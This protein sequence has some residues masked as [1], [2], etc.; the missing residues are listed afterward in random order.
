MDGWERPC[1]KEARGPARE[2]PGKEGS[3]QQEQQVQRPWGGM[4]LTSCRNGGEEA[5]AAGSKE[6][7][8]RRGNQLVPGASHVM[9]STVPFVPSFQMHV[10]DV[11]IPCSFCPPTYLSR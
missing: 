10:S 6:V 2:G 1:L 4:R 3:Q 11:G 5:S 7:G 9:L 8:G